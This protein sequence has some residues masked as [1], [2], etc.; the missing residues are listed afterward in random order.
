MA[1]SAR[2]A[3]VGRR[4]LTPGEIARGAHAATVAD[5]PPLSF[6]AWG[7]APTALPETLPEAAPPALRPVTLPPP[8]QEMLTATPPTKSTPLAPTAM[9]R[10]A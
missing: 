5:L 8:P 6:A 2:R 7:E 4:S 10:W 3:T 1:T 9:P